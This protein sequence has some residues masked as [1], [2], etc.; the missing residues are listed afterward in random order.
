M[1]TKKPSRTK[2][3]AKPATT[4]QNLAARPPSDDEDDG[5]LVDTSGVFRVTA[6]IARSQIGHGDDSTPRFPNE[7][8]VMAAQRDG[9]R[10]DVTTLDD[11]V[12]DNVVDDEATAAEKR[13]RLQTLAARARTRPRR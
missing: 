2:P 3:K 4:L 13:A 7:S 10:A 8:I 12:D 6:S 5:Q 9:F 1:A 11:V